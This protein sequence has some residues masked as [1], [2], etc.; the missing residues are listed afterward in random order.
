LVISA[1]RPP[2]ELD[3]LGPELT[4]RLSGGMV[5]RLE[6]PDLPTR[7]SLAHQFAKRLEIELPEAVAGHIAQLATENAREI[8]GAV[9]RVHAASRI[10]KRPIDLALVQES[11]ADMF[12]TGA[13]RPVGMSDIE[14]AVCEVFGV[15]QEHLKSARR[16]KHVSTARMLAMWL[17]RKHT[18]A[19]LSEIGD[20]FG[21]RSHSTVISAYKRVGDWIAEQ[22]PI[23]LP[24]DRCSATEA[25]R[26]VE[27]RFRVG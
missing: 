19:G 4:N 5:C 25:V 2:H 1:D 26:R 17:A 6:S 8:S 11:L 24:G 15:S 20:Y 14:K 16:A 27:Q 18:R 3:G 13:A 10:L 21:R 23:E 7:I 9:N 12:E 22:S